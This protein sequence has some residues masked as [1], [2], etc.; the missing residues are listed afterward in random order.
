MEESQLTKKEKRAIAKEEK[1]KLNK[2]RGYFSWIRRLATFGV[3]GLV[4][5]FLGSKLVGWI[6]KPQLEILGDAIEVFDDDWVKGAG[7]ASVTLIEYSDFE[8]PSCASYSQVIKKLN[9]D[10]PDGLRVVYRHFPL[11]SI[12][13]N[14]FSAAVAAEAAGRQDKFWEMH[15]LLF[16]KQ[17]EWSGD[18][19]PEDK[20]MGYAR[21][22]GLE[23]DAF[24][25]DLDSE[26]IKSKVQKHES[27]AYKLRLDYTPSLFIN[28]EKVQPTSYETIRN[29]IES[30]I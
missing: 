23:E 22:L 16:G 20:Y 1:R 25:N 30:K 28:G 10:F 17:E 19:T 7:D 3:A 9:E 14:A 26:E 8:C 15:D 18:R 21:E 13:K 5:F 29:L 12:H 24:K 2:R 11:S 27:S 6:K 4:L